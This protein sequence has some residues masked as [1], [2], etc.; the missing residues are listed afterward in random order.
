MRSAAVG[1]FSE[2]RSIMAADRI[3]ASGFARFLPAMSGALPWL[4]SYR[5]LPDEF[6]DADGSMP[7]EPV[8]IAASSERMSPNMLPVTITSKD[9][10]ARTS[11]IAALSTYM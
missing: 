6:N 10:G 11:C 4:G 5:P 2:K 9:F 3:V 1:W 7:I 8:S